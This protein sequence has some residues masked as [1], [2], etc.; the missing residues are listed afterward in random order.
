M[1]FRELSNHQWVLQSW[2]K[3]CGNLL[4]LCNFD[5]PQAKRDLISSITLL[6]N[7]LGS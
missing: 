2:P 3:Y 5:S 7:D 6:P 4:F 1:H